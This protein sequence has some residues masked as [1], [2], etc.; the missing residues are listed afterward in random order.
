MSDAHSEKSIGESRSMC[1][2]NGKNAQP[3]LYDSDVLF[4]P[5]HDPPKVRSTEEGN[6]IEDENRLRLEE[7]MNDPICIEK[8]VIIKPYDYH[9]ENIVTIFSPQTKLTPGQIC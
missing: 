4:T 9:K 7:K 2:R 1:L 6:L 3:A 8:R 5:G